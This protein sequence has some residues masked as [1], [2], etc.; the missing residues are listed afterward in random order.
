MVHDGDCEYNPYTNKD[1]YNIQAEEEEE[2]PE[3]ETT[4]Q[5]DEL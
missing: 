4:I 2:I 3:T 5:H 1:Y